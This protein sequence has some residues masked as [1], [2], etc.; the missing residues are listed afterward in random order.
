MSVKIMTMVW[1]HAPCREN[2]LIVLLALA[3]W[4]ND[5]G[6]CWPSIQKL[7]DKTRIDRRSA[8]RIIRR[9]A[10]DNLITIEEGGGRAKQHRYRIETA[11]LC[12]PLA[13]ETAAESRPSREINSD[14][15]DTE[16]AALRTQRA[17]FRAETATPVS[18]DPLEEPLEEP[19]VDPLAQP[20]F[21][22]PEFR[23]A[24][25]D[26]EQ[27][28]KEKRIKVTPT[29]RRLM[30]K[31][32]SLWGEQRSTAALIHSTEKGYTGC[33]EENGNGTIH[34]R[35]GYETAAEKRG[36]NFRSQIDIVNQLRRESLRDHNESE[37]GANA[38]SRT[39]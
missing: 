30:F 22:S 11:A 8:Q 16:R 25:K 35:N 32:F 38:L 9:L 20:P 36:R 4:S 28:R 14:F 34:Q 23:S 17:T 37:S 6:E 29:A 15:P 39:G 7:A 10:K 26:F 2:A 19:S 3:D 13:V 1:E 12:R 27:H 5:S 33:F 18:P 31:K 24:L 21:C